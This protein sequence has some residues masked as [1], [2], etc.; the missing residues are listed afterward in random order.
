LSE[1][2]RESTIGESWKEM[3]V[4]WL[5]RKKRLI[6]ILSIKQVGNIYCFMLHILIKN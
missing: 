6:I 4:D 2:L 5:P 1:K 3:L